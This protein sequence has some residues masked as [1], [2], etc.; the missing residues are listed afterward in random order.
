MNGFSIKENIIKDVKE[1]YGDKYKDPVIDINIF[2]NE[3]FGS[4]NL[5]YMFP[6][7]SEFHNKVLPHVIEKYPNTNRVM[8]F[9]Q[10]VFG[11]DGTPSINSNCFLTTEDGAIIKHVPKTIEEES[12]QLQN[13][14][15]IVV[16]KNIA[17]LFE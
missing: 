6:I 10:G 15:Q 8:I 11:L 1:I 7:D 13:S 16:F 2:N 14:L 5:S 17:P 12:K 4:Y 3:T 9:C